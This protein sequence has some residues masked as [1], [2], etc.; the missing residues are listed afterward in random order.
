MDLFTNA[1]DFENIFTHLDVDGS[2]D[3]D[4]EE[5]KAL[6]QHNASC[7]NIVDFIPLGEMKGGRE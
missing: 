3:L 4:W 1:S 6:T 7:S 5:F 2:G